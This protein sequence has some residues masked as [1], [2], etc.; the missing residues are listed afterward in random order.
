MGKYTNI[1]SKFLKEKIKK[2]NWENKKER[3]KIDDLIFI[4]DYILGK[5]NLRGG[6]SRKLYNYSEEYKKMLKELK[7]KEFAKINKQEAKENSKEKREE[8]KLKK[9][10]KLIEEKNKK[11]WIEAGGR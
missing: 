11:D 6:G 3:E 2:S 8:M 9:E 10:E 1:K 5:V 4:E 7:P